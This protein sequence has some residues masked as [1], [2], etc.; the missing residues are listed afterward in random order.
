MTAIDIRNV[1]FSYNGQPV[2]E[3]VCLRV[4]DADFLAIIGPNGGGKT[5][6]L[7]LIL[8]LLRPTAGG[9]A[10]F[11]A[12][13]GAPV[14]GYV[15][16]FGAL[17]DTFPFRVMDVV[18]TGR[19][20]RSSLGPWSPA[21]DRDAAMNVLEQLGMAGLARRRF[22]ELSG[23]QRQRALIARALL[24]EPRLLLLDEPTASVDSQVEQDIYDLLHELN[25]SIPIVL[26]THDLGFVARYVTRVACLNRRLT[27]HGIGDI[28][29]EDIHTL[30]RRNMAS[31]NHHC[32]L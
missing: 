12:P 18:L 1:W 20:R 13:V 23:G 24:S 16:Q 28:G 9:I 32:G 11:G 27:V 31:V 2:L 22:G 26:V 7:K 5:T 15:P 19:L 10:V 14:M 8:G 6:L 4:T 30:Y 21:A 29:E 3:D 17:D 25:G